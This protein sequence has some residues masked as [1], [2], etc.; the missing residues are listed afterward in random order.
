MKKK[1]A[2]KLCFN[3]TNLVLSPPSP[4]TDFIS[5]EEDLDCQTLNDVSPVP[6]ETPTLPDG[7]LTDTQILSASLILKKTFPD[8][9]GLQDTI[10]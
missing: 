4:A 5:L 1:S 8:V 7:C 10:L 3:T 6:I 2:K 9:S